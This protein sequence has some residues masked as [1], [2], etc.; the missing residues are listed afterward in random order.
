[1]KIARTFT[2]DYHL[3]QELRKKPNQSRI[4]ERSIRRYLNADED[5]S[6]AEINT[7]PLLS[8]VMER[9]DTPRQI[10]LLIKDYLTSV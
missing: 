1:M 6:V 4:V 7:I 5:F 3:Y 9:E 8:I 10:K 2:I